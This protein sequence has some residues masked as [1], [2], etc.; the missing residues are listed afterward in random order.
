MVQAA[1][2]ISVRLFERRDLTPLRNLTFYNFHI[3]SHLDWQT[4]YE[5]LQSDPG[6]V[7][8]AARRG[9]VVAVIGI[10]QPV[11]GACWIRLMA[12]DDD[13][14]PAE[15]LD[16]LWKT[17]TD[18]LRAKART[19][20]LLVMQDWT[21]DW[22]RTVGFRYMEKIVT[23]HRSLKEPPPVEPP[24]DRRVPVY[25]LEYEDLRAVHAV[26]DAAFAAP[27]RLT[28]SE[29]R[30]GMRVSTYSTLVLLNN[31]IV[32]YQISTTHGMNG[33]LARLGVAPTCQGRGI[34]G[35]LVYN[36]VSHFLNRRVS[37]LSVNT[38]ETNLRS[39]RL[40]QRFGFVRNGYDLPV[41]HYKL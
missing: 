18:D 16:S 21:Y 8:V 13:E 32:G 9:R 30:L 33:H 4:V 20:A 5:Y 41:W 7:W 12:V 39:Q 35:E 23:L 15:I 2:G 14:D 25:P 28:R 31:T 27:W 38:Q 19:V 11:G 22:A 1:P 24:L 29:L 40:Y 17:A 10:S 36:M 3:H 6:N 26:D 34:G 37:S